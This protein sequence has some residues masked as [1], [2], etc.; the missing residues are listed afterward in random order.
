M[1]PSRPCRTGTKTVAYTMLVYHIPCCL[2]HCCC[3][4]RTSLPITGLPHK[5]KCGVTKNMLFQQS[6]DW[7]NADNF[8]PE[9][10]GA[11]G[12]GGP[13]SLAKQGRKIRRRIR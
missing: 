7:R 11:F 12:M 4:R 5:Q 9:F 8:G 2:I 1:K 6:R 13:K 3:L 10:W